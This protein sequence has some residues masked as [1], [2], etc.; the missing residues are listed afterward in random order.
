M[1]I[2]I[3]PSEGSGNNTL[4]IKSFNGAASS[5]EIS[6]PVTVTATAGYVW[7]AIGLV[8]VVGIVTVLYFRKNVR[9]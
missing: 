8:L 6:I 7:W 5:Q 3:P 9:R 4:K 2:S 1:T